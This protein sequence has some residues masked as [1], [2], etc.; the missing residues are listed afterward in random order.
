MVETRTETLRRTA[1]YPLHVEY[2]AKLVPFAGYEMPVQFP[3]GVK[4]EHLW[5]RSEA[6][7]FDVSHMGPSFLT[8]AAG[9]RADPAAHA[10][11]AAMVETLVPSDIRGLKPGQARLTVLLDGEGGILDDLIITRPY[12]EDR[13][14]ELYIVVNGAMKDQDWGIFESALAG[15]A[16]L[17]RADDGVLFALQ[18]PKAEKV[19]SAYFP[20]CAD[21]K[22]MESRRIVMHGETFVVSRCGYTGEDGYEVWSGAAAGAELVRL[23]LDDPCVRPI[24]LGARDSLRLEAGL[25]L[26]GHDLSP[27]ISPVEADL[28]WVIQKRRREAGD[29]PGAARILRELKDGPARRRV[30]IRPLERA[31][32]REGTEIFVGGAA[33]GVVTSGGFGPSIDA[34]VTMGY[35]DAAHAAPGTKIDLMVRGK[36]RPA[37]IAS[38]PFIPTRYKR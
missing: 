29:F 34:P 11:I 9:T 18:G 27:E 33:V 5:T 21:L 25:C 4:E 26:Y 12:E 14:G 36:A 35:V 38:L 3:D 37:E 19:L 32:A 6:G 15:R 2:G 22:F 20:A 1:L 13:Q 7:L 30:G 24:G 17:T 8:L 10:E 16:V 23:L 31:P 28:A